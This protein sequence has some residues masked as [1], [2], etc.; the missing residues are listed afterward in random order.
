[1]LVSKDAPE[2]QRRFANSRGWRFKLASHGGGDYIR[3]Q[4][5]MEG[6]DNMPGAVMYERKGQ[7]IFLEILGS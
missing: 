3:E 4:T 5:V 6:P 2:V 7:T 1:V